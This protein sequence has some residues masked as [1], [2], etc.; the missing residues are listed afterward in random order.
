MDVNPALSGSTEYTNVYTLY[1]LLPVSSIR[2]TTNRDPAVSAALKQTP[3]SRERGVGSLVPQ[4]APRLH[5]LSSFLAH[6]MCS[7]GGRPADKAD[8]LSRS[9]RW[10]PS[11]YKGLADP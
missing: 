2:E 1:H 5:L 10:C 8:G 9:S 11:L 4:G 7:G 3:L 6:C